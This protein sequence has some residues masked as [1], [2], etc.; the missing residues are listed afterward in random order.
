MVAKDEKLYDAKHILL[1][2][3]RVS[4]S[5]KEL[6]KENNFLEQ[7][8]DIVLNLARLLFL[9]DSIDI[10][11]D[12][13]IARKRVTRQKEPEIPVDDVIYRYLLKIKHDTLSEADI[14][15]LNELQQFLSYSKLHQLLSLAIDQKVKVKKIHDDSSL[16]MSISELEVFLKNG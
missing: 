11:G 2:S 9:A 3:F 15:K 4:D 7:N 13:I 14:S 5:V 8:K 10:E 12:E 16:K 1:E 6:L